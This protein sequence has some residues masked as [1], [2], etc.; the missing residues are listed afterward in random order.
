[1]VLTLI[2][3]FF[4]GVPHPV[5]SATH[6]FDGWLSVVLEPRKRLL[7]VSIARKKPP[8]DGQQSARETNQEES[9]TYLSGKIIH[10]TI[11]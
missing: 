7:L 5:F 11:I 9:R 3:A 10:T 2:V 4:I 8:E 1:M 6:L